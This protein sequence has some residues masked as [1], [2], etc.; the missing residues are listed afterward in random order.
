MGEVAA[1]EG[2]ELA[3]ELVFVLVAVGE[4]EVAGGGSC[5]W[6]AVNHAGGQLYAIGDF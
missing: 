6:Q 4:V 1:E 2:G 3:A 5:V